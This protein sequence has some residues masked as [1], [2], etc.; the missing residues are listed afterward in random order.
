[1]GKIVG[2]SLTSKKITVQALDEI[3]QQI[4]RYLLVQLLSSIVV[5]IATGL[6][7]WALGSS[8]R[9]CGASAPRS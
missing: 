8:M 4:Q 3:T 5:G 9:R 1:M 7:F 2:P 6:A